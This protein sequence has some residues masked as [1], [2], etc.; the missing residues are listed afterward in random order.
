MT[1]VSLRGMHLTILA[2]GLIAL[3]SALCYAI[4]PNKVVQELA[5]RSWL[6][7]M[8]GVSVALGS[9]TFHL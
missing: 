3:V 4:I 1:R 9:S 7:G 8:I 5:I 6:A 2:P